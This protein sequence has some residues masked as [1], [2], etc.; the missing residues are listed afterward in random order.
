MSK[1]HLRTKTAFT[2]IDLLVVIAIIAIL[3]AILF[4]VFARARENA[5]RTS[6][7]SNLKQLGI[8]MIQYTQD[9]DERYPACWYGVTPAGSTN[10]WMVF[11]QPYIKSTQVFQ[12]PSESAANQ[13]PTGSNFPTHYAYNYYIGGNPGSTTSTITNRVLAELV[14][15]SQTVL[16]TDGGSL[17]PPPAHQTR[18]ERRQRNGRFV[19]LPP[20]AAPT[21][22]TY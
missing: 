15:P 9:Y 12:C 16:M 13:G 5:R 22:L 10:T 21:R 14:K 18:M 8:M 4:P 20:L 11:M 17:P 3:A 1:I 6:C 19:S 7:T 2:L